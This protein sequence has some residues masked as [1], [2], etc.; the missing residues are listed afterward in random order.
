VVAADVGPLAET[1]RASDAGWLYAAGHARALADAM[2]ALIADPV[3]RAA[4]GEAG[5]DFVRRN[6]TW[7]GNAR[8][9][10]GLV[11]WRAGAA[12]VRGGTSDRREARIDRTDRNIVPARRVA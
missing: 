4:L 12:P 6:H 8:V 5:R 11:G 1:V 10:E 7:D 2:A 9:V 3:T